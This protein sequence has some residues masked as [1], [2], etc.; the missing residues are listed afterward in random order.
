MERTL[1]IRIWSQ[2][3]LQVKVP[4]TDIPFT[5]I[6]Q[7]LKE[8][9]K[10]QTMQ[11]SG[12]VVLLGTNNRDLKLTIRISGKSEKTISDSLQYFDSLLLQ[13]AEYIYLQMQ[14]YTLATYQ[15]SVDKTHEK[16]NVW[17]Q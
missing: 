1:D 7:Y 6:H 5:I 11:I 14:P 13:A 15:Y 12:E 16:K 8:L 10:P 2:K 4:G 3:Q 17:Q 9:F